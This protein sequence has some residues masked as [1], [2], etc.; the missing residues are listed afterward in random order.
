MKI[1][2][3][4]RDRHDGVDALKTRLREKG[5]T[6][7]CYGE[8]FS[9][10]EDLPGDTELFLSLGGDGT[11][12]QS[13]TFIR[14]RGIPVAGINFGRLGF[15]TTARADEGDRWIDELLAG[16]YS[17]EERSLLRV[18]CAD[19][20]EDFYPFALNEISIQRRGASMLPVHVCIDG[21]ELPTYWADGLVVS[22]PTG[23]TAYNLSVGGPVVMPSSEVM[24]I[25]PIAPHNLNVRP[26]VV[27]M[28]AAVELTF[29]SREQDALLT[30]DNR[31]CFLPSGTTV[32]L[33][34][35]RYGLRYVSLSDNSFIG[36]LRTKLLWGEDRR[37]TNR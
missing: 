14:D 23:S 4:N 7:A 28:D 20:P 21:R 27:P 15:L 37:N 12:L 11:F 17:V 6:L 16:H 18:T 13:L 29:H 34:R 31:S 10:W 32:S 30:L 5:A 9:S 24:V 25:A 33:A 1:A 3:Y 22:T 8:D 35:G 26:L 36:A 19:L 2:L